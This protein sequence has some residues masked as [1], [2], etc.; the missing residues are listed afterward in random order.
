MYDW[1]DSNR[2]EIDDVISKVMR[3]I[4]KGYRKNRE[5]FEKIVLLYAW[6]EYFEIRSQELPYMGAWENRE[7]SIDFPFDARDAQNSEAVYEMMGAIAD[8]YAADGYIV[9]LLDREPGV[10]MI[11]ISW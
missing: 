11:S 3:K 7:D 4:D 8:D 2:P 6:P 5:E 1:F 10:P 9:E